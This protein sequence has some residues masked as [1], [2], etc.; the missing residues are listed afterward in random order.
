MHITAKQA[1]N[2]IGISKTAVINALEKHTLTGQKNEEGQWLVDAA[3]ATRYRD[4]RQHK[5]A[6]HQQ[7]VDDIKANVDSGLQVVVEAKDK[8]IH[9][10]NQRLNDQVESHAQVVA[11]KDETIQSLRLLSDQRAKEAG[12]LPQEVVEKIAKLEAERDLLAAQA[13]KA[14]KLQEE[15]VTARQ[16]KKA[17]EKAAAAAQAAAE[18]AKTK[19]LWDRWV[20]LFEKKA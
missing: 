8:V 18:A 17:A 3:D 1:A 19:S 12:Q 5:T 15:L 6:N 14:E 20:D 4:S 11:A 10:L 2:L 16:E 9:E 13:T 7:V